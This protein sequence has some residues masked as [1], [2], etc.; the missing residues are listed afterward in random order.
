VG[1]PPLHLHARA[2]TV[3]ISKNKPPVTVQ[4]PVPQHML[5]LL[6]ACGWKDSS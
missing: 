3:P 5:E 2:V 1:G 6:T 4:A